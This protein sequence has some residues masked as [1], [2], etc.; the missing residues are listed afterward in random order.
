M[1]EDVSLPEKDHLLD[2]KKNIKKWFDE[3]KYEVLVT[4]INTLKQEQVVDA[5]MGNE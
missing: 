1:K 4:V 2:V 3:G 5:R